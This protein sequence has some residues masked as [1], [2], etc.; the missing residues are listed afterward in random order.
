MAEISNPKIKVDLKD[1]TKA[2]T[3][4]VINNLDKIEK[5]SSVLTKAFSNI[6]LGLFGAG[7][8][9]VTSKII[10]AT[11][12]SSDFIE[13]LNVLDVAFNDNTTGIRKFTSNIAE[14]LNL[15]DA[16]I[17]KMA[18]SFK[19][20]GNSMGYADEMGTK[21]SK[22]MTS[23]T[24]DTASLFN[25]S[26][27]NT[28]AML[29]SAVQ[30]QTK[31]LRKQTGV[32]I[33]DRDVQTTLDVLGI[34]AYVQNMNSAEKSLA[35]V[36]TMTY[37]LRDS[38]GDLARTI[39]SPANRFRVLSEQI[40]LLGR[41]I[42]NVLLP[43]I[44]AVLPYLNAVLIV[45]NKLISSLASLLGFN[46]KNW[47]FFGKKAD[48]LSEA[49]DDFGTSVGGV[50]TA[51]KKTKKELSGLREFDKLNVIKTPTDTSS[52]GGG[53]GGA[54]SGINPNLL[55]AFDLMFD[56]YNSRLDGVKTKATEIAEA[57]MKALGSIDFSNL[58]ASGK[59]L[60]EAFK[61]FAENVGKGLLW[62]FEN[63]L[64]PIGKWYIEDYLPAWLD[65]LASG[66]KV[67]NSAIKV[68][69]P[70]AKW[71]FDNFL[72]PIGKFAG[73]VVVN[74]MKG[75]SD[76]LDKISKNKG[77]SSF[78]TLA[79]GALL[80]YTNLGKVKDVMGKSKLLGSISNLLEPTKKLMSYVGA[81]VSAYGKLGDGIK[82]A[83][84]S[85]RASE[86]I[87]DK[88][89]GKL[90]GYQGSVIAIKDAFK[91]L[92]VG[93][94]SLV[95]VSTAFQD[96]GTNGINA[97]NA[98]G[99]LAGAIGLVS[100]AMQVGASLIPHYGGLI[101]G[102]VGTVGLL[103]TAF[104][105]YKNATKDA[106]SGLEEYEKAQ[107][108]LDDATRD[109]LETDLVELDHIDKLS[110]ELGNLV[111]AN[112]KVK[113]G[114]EKRVNY[115]LNELNNAFGTE[116]KLID[117]V[118]TKNGKA[119]KSY[120]EV[121]KEIQET[122][123]WKKAEA[124]QEA[125]KEDYIKALKNEKKGQ[126]AV[127]TAEEE[128]TKQLQKTIDKYGEKGLAILYNKN[129]TD[130][131]KAAVLG[132]NKEIMLSD[133]EV[134]DQ[135]KN[136]FDAVKKG[137]E[138]NEKII[139]NYEKLQEAIVN[140]DWNTTLKYLDNYIDT[141]KMKT[142][143][144]NKDVE[145]TSKNLST[146]LSSIFDKVPKTKTTKVKVEADT[147]SFTSTI[148]NAFKN[149]KIGSIN[150]SSLFKANGGILVNGKW[151]DIAT[152][153]TGG[154]P[155]VGQMFVA[156]ERGPELVGNIGGHTAVMNNNQIVSSV[157]AGVYQAVKGAMGN[158]NNNNGVY[159]IY[160]DKDHKLGSYTLEQLQGMAKSNGKPIT[161]G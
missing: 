77:L 124:V 111:D 8:A 51:A 125:F 42:G 71:L 87:I 64:V 142:D 73:N 159:N 98:L 2:G 161:I 52:G 151:R 107:K 40:S 10:Q 154:L 75:I 128:Y 155:P 6:K 14:T 81:G 16:S 96:I 91:G 30:G 1:N 121:E 59:R 133:K 152:Y 20:L 115:I 58:I 150:L 100:G 158:I 12:K 127:K 34:D 65:L 141:S 112:G 24:V 9:G 140:K 22:L 33:L 26:L 76:A 48:T 146:N 19:I 56:N 60:W 86:G 69:K 79:G 44:Y 136:M 78:T 70:T 7:I 153:D 11:K 21:F 85:W 45:L 145:K 108:R 82:T 5:K 55:K 4:S 49:F 66:F 149:I 109:K 119:V 83:T 28:Q 54:G 37:R 15:D 92:L 143:K 27:S 139:G 63:V 29:Q 57:I 118:I 97:G 103:I 148:K 147:S 67:L 137:Y 135:K 18:S 23:I 144:Y 84:D 101:G 38:Q 110:N 50:G 113:D 31:A 32:S 36:I 105:S 123:K 117:G 89:T 157:S 72:K 68:F 95:A 160:L 39:E 106:T 93:T 99:G 122:I 104:V 132:A 43:A 116:Y 130:E 47:D 13:Q 53:G 102:L 134:L 156:R 25:M 17:I 131:E 138:N 120:Q 3:Q 80:L 129:M 61:P 88:Q 62:T 94:F 90:N 126:E 74:W 46:E 114:Y 35:R 41:N